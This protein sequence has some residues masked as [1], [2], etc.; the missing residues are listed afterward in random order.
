MKIS[1]A[2]P[3][4]YIKA[5]DLQG[6]PVRVRM[7]YVKIEKIGDDEKPVLYFIGKE[8]ALALNKTNANVIALMYGDDTDNWAGGEIEIYPTETDFQGKRVDAIRVRMA[9]RQVD[10]NDRIAPNARARQEQ[11]PPPP[12]PPHDNTGAFDD[13][14][15]F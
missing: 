10:Q 6:R 2:F 15:P 1:S 7:N 9:S 14:I 8:K 12:P 11:E 4:N 5:S 13:E 3:S